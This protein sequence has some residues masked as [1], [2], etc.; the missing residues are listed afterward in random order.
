MTV[1]FMW[2]QK[3]TRGTFPSWLSGGGV[4]IP[5]FKWRAP[6]ASTLSCSLWVFCCCFVI[7]SLSMFNSCNSSSEQVQCSSIDSTQTKAFA[8]FSRCSPPKSPRGWWRWLCASQHL[9]Q[10][11]H[12]GRRRGQE[13]ERAAAC[14]APGDEDLHRSWWYQKEALICSA[15]WSTRDDRSKEFH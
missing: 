15:G 13:G 5:S 7:Q 8:R 6:P 2:V 14:P 9:D 3:W 4:A 11:L 12:P 10:Q 1:N